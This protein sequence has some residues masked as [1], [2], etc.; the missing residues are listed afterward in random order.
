MPGCWASAADGTVTADGSLIN[1]NKFNSC[2]SAR[3]DSMGKLNYFLHVP[4]FA[5]SPSE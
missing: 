3:V 1:N 2:V 5:N 4:L